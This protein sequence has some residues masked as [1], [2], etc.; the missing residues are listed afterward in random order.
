MICE[1]CGKDFSG[2]TKSEVVVLCE[3]C[4]QDGQ[5]PPAISPE[6]SADKKLKESWPLP[7]MLSKVDSLAKL[8]AAVEGKLSTMK[9]LIAILSVASFLAIFAGAAFENWYLLA[10]CVAALIIVIIIHS[11][12]KSEDLGNELRL[13]L[14]P[15]LK[16]LKDD[17]KKDSL[18]DLEVALNRIDDR[19]FWKR[20][21]SYSITRYKCEANMF[22][23]NLLDLSVRL[24][25]GNSLSLHMTESLIKIQKTR[26]VGK[27]KNKYAFKLRTRADLKLGVNEDKYDIRISE[28]SGRQYQYNRDSNLIRTGGI[29]KD[30]GKKG[31]VLATQYRVKYRKAA[32][33]DD[34]PMPDPL[35][36]LDQLVALYACLKPKAA[37]EGGK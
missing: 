7:Q 35:F 19:C 15:L 30:K 21:K 25:D 11:L 16:H 1:K 31:P 8:D 13:F 37:S 10:V 33:F 29:R 26:T 9:M 24:H 28:Q 4:L 23:R 12:K 18:V 2:K 34:I 5:A 17:L 36:A 20:E 32:G 6:L 27:A 14:G 22:Q 3:N